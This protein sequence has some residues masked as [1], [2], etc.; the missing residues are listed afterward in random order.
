VRCGEKL[1]AWGVEKKLIKTNYI[2]DKRPKPTMKSAL[3]RE[4][5][6]LGS[7]EREKK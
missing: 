3:W 4:T 1:A 2:T 7:R 5:G 6:C